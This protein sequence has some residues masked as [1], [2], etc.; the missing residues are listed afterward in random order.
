MVPLVILS[1]GTGFQAQGPH[2]RECSESDYFKLDSETLTSHRQP[3]SLSGRSQDGS[4]GG[5]LELEEN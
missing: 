3:G 4:E 5:L 2:L 1:G